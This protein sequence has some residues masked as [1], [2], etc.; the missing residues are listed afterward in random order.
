ML[1]ADFTEAMAVIDGILTRARDL[2]EP[3]SI[4]GALEAAKAHDR[5]QN[6]KTDP[7][8]DAWIPWRPS[9]SA[10]MWATA[11]WRSGAATS[12]PCSTNSAHAAPVS[13][14]PAI[15]TCPARFWDG[16]TTTYPITP[17]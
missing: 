6:S 13:V 17:A 14:H 9:P 16:R 12:S 4:I 3:L 8:G 7:E 2:T 1:E 15:T 10:L 5:I 11:A